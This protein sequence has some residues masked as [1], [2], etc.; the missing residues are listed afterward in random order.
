MLRIAVGQMEPIIGDLKGNLQ[1][2]SAILSTATKEEVD[3]LV[4]PELLNSGYVFESKEEAQSLLEEIPRGLFSKKLKKWSENGGMVVAGLCE[5]TPDAIY[6]SAAIFSKGDHVSTYRKIHLFDEELLWFSAGEKEPPIVTYND[7][8]FGVIICY[9][10][11]FPEL[12]R[13]LALGGAQIILHPA[14][15]I[16]TSLYC[17]KAM[18]TRSIENRVFTATASRVGMER[19]LHFLGASQ[20]TDPRG[21]VLLSM[22]DVETG[23]SWVDIDPAVADNKTITKR[24]DILNDRKPELYRRIIDPK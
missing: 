5:K 23:I 6:N 10:W 13:V 19:N 2:M 7:Y 11:A 14:N 15:L 1:K 22:D 9:D 4:L 20:V 17:S 18:I 12:S 24:N 16:L 21:H 8:R 3:V